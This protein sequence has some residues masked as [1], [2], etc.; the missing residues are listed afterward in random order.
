MKKHEEHF[1][2]RKRHASGKFHLLKNEI[3]SL[4]ARISLKSSL[5]ISYGDT[6]GQKLDI[7]PAKD[8]NSPVFVFIHGGYFR[9]LDKK[10]YNYIAKP[11]VKNAVTTV[12]INYDLAP[13]VKV[14][15]IIEQNIKAF[16]WIYNNIKNYN[17]D[18]KKIFI[19]GH[20]VG[21]FLCAKILEYDYSKEI[22]ESIIG[23]ALLSGIY[24]LTKIE[25]SYLNEDL[26]LLKNDVKELSPLFNKIK[27]A[28]YTIIAVGDKETEEFIKQSKMYIKKLKQENVLSEFM[29]LKDKN[30]YTVSRMLS[31]TKN[32]L[33]EKILELLK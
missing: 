8:K 31:N 1:N 2:L 30:H 24:D 33:M 9:A 15:Q 13:K 11:F 14:S 29:L 12:I 27:K 10:S 28:P 5:D 19:C 16:E 25:E 18:S 6:L 7:F 26:H 32:L 21:A 22:K 23:V 17:G 4:I 3:E 20:S